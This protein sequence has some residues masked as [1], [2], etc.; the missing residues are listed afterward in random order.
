MNDAACLHTEGSNEKQGACLPA[1]DI[2]TNSGRKEKGSSSHTVQ[3]R[4]VD[5]VL[6]F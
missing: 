2:S 1:S 3:E 6:R 4:R 5:L